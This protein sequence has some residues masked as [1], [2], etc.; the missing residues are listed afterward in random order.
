MVVSQIGTETMVLLTSRQRRFD[1]M[2]LGEE[3]GWSSIPGIV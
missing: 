1:M 2:A 3:S